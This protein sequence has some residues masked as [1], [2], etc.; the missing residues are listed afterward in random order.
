[1]VQATP[2]TS[3]VS[4]PL[5]SVVSDTSLNAITSS[6]AVMTEP[7]PEYASSLADPSG[8]PEERTALCRSE[9]EQV[10]KEVDSELR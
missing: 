6:S 4:T 1:L 2:R 5:I 10:V 3:L 9:I 7:S 8:Q